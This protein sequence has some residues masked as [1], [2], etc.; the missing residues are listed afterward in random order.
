[1]WNQLTHVILLSH[2]YGWREDDNCTNCQHILQSVDPSATK[3]HKAVS[4]IISLPRFIM[5][6]QRGG[7]GKRSFGCTL[8]CHSVV[9]AALLSG[10]EVERRRTVH[11]TGLAK[12]LTSTQWMRCSRNNVPVLQWM[13][14]EWVVSEW[15]REYTVVSECFFDSFSFGIFSNGLLL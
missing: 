11:L 7:E 2:G 1:M 3:Q 10:D 14:S 12:K 13:E 6:I 9:C 5:A 15:V 4:G 8:H